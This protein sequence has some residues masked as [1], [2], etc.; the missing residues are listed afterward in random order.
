MRTASWPWGSLRARRAT[1]APTTVAPTQNASVTN[2]GSSSAAVFAFS[3]PRGDGVATVTKTGTSGNVDTYTMTSDRGVTLGT[4]T[5]TNGNVSSV[6]SKTGA[7]VLDAG[8]LG[9]DGS[10]TYSGGTV[11]SELSQLKSQINEVESGFPQKSASGS[12]V[13]IEDG[14]DNVP[15]VSLTAQIVPV[16]SGTGEPAPDNVR[17]ISGWT[18]ANVFDTGVNVWDGEIRNGYYQVVSG[19]FASLSTSIANKN[20]IPVKPS[21]S[22]YFK[23]G[24]YNV[25][26]FYY[27]ADMNYITYGYH[28]GNT[29]ITTP[30]N[31]AFLCFCN[32]FNSGG[33]YA[34]D[35][36]INYPSTDHSYH[37]YTGRTVNITF[38]DSAGTVYGGS[39]TLNQ[40]G[41]ADLTVTK[42]GVTYDGTEDGWQWFET[43][44]QASIPLLLSAKY[45][46]YAI[47]YL[48]NRLRP[49]TNSERASYAGNYA[50]LVG[51]GTQVAFSTP[52][53][54]LEDFKTWAG[55]HNIQFVYELATPITYHITD[56]DLVKTLYGFNNLWAD[57]GDID[58]TYRCDPATFTAE[59]IRLMLNAM[60]APVEATTT[61]SQAYSVNDFLIMDGTLYKV[62]ANI[63]SGGTITINTNVS[64]TTIGAEITNILNN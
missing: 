32:D 14:A 33:T 11:G 4:F 29:V 56:V 26:T 55:T 36:S 8:D 61:A 53:T 18:G 47:S 21:T 28:V 51:S 6:N 41:S 35:I 50:S 38:P 15:V 45:S 16:Q 37:A 48:C 13:T 54:S 25:S 52:E 12:I 49:C 3:I 17:P 42:I 62:I 59:S 40:D 27:D 60:V 31:C 63:A 64:A 46:Q 20:P 7:V 57:T 30:A 5:V 24:S 39:I 23:S 58:V 9:Y 44:N 2:T 22:Y 10:E 1:P 34:N 19:A 43:L